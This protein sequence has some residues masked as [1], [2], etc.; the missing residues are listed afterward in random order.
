MSE[1]E[2]QVSLPE[3]QHWPVENVKPYENNPRLNEDA[4]DGVVSSIKQF[5]FLVPIT[6]DKDGVIITGHTR[7]LASQKLGLTTVP[8]IVATHLNDAQVAAFRLADNRLSENAKWD[9]SKLSQELDYIKGMGFSLE[10]TG[11]SKEELDCLCGVV[12]ADCLEG[13]DYEAVCGQVVE[14]EAKE[15]LSVRVAA[16]N[17]NFRLSMEEFRLWE[18][19]MLSEFGSAGE[20]VAFMRKSLRMDE[21]IAEAAAAAKSNATSEATA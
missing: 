5:G 11:F 14:A 18:E 2:N 8:V 12:T 20:V 15:S 19:K 13:L 16:G 3:I 4:V 6:V 21:A 10:F 17:Y 7:L 1:Q 9:E